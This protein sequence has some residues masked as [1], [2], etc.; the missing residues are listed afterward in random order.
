MA[1]MARMAWRLYE[2]PPIHLFSLNKVCRAIEFPSHATIPTS[3][4]WQ[5]WLLP[6][7]REGSRMDQLLGLALVL[8]P[9]PLLPELLIGFWVGCLAYLKSVSGLLFGQIPFMLGPVILVWMH[10]PLMWILWCPIWFLYFMLRSCIFLAPLRGRLWVA[11]WLGVGV[12]TYGLLTTLG[13]I[14][15]QPKQSPS[16]NSPGD[17]PDSS[18]PV[19]RCT[20]ASYT[21]TAHWMARQIPPY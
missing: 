17:V 18:P 20:P 6:Q 4:L 1:F 19:P 16:I 21:E 5:Q 3:K 11:G 9:L 12:S 15:S 13:N 7:L 10:M 2:L 8:T 14:Q